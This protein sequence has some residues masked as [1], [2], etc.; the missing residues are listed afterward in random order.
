MWYD[1]TAVNLLFESG[2]GSMKQSHLD[3]IEQEV[4]WVYDKIIPHLGTTGRALYWSKEEILRRS[5]MKLKAS[6]IRCEV[7]VDITITL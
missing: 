6:K 1:G 5:N 4:I 3:H 7:T 2:A